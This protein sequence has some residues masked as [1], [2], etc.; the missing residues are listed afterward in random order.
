MTQNAT[1]EDRNHYSVVM[2][3]ETITLRLGN[4]KVGQVAVSSFFFF[5]MLLGTMSFKKEKKTEPGD[6]GTVFET[7]R[8]VGGSKIAGP[9]THCL[10]LIICK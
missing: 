1:I 9:V 2:I 3:Y 4:Q 10:E 8:I 6:G 5:S 7:L